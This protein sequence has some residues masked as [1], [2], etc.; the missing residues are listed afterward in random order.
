MSPRRLSFW[1]KVLLLA[2]VVAAADGLIFMA[3]GLGANLGLI[4]LT[5]VVALILAVPAIIRDRLSRLALAVAIL[6]ALLQIERASAVGWLL[7]LI[8]LGVAMLALR[9][10]RGEDAWKWFQ[11]LVV[12]ALKGLIAPIRDGRRLLQ[13]RARLR[14]RKLID[15]VLVAALPLLGGAVFLGLFAEANPVIA[16]VLGALRLPDADFARLAFGMAVALVVWA[17]L[18][19]GGLR[20]TLRLAGWSHD[21]SLPGVS[22]ASI[23]AS[24]MVFNAIFALQNG[25]DIA[26]LWGGVGLPEGM[27]F[28]EYAHRGAYP[29]IATALL[30]GLFVVVFLQPGSLTASDRRIRVLVTVWVAQN[31]FLVASTALRT[32]DYIDAYSLTRTRI[33]A[34]LWMGLVA[35]GLVLILWRLL[36]RRS[37]AWLVNANVLAAGA[38]L[39]LCSAIDLGAIAAAWNVRHAR[40]VGGRGVALDL[41]YMRREL[42]GAALLPLA[43]LETSAIS[44]DLRDRVRFVRREIQADVVNRQSGWREWRWRD[45]RR[46][47]ALERSL[48]EDHHRSFERRDCSGRPILPPA[49]AATPPLT[50]TAKP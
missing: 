18:R 19:P 10:P 22:T 17:T 28:A 23:A 40:E 21:R 9:A 3:H 14:P 7:F 42:G 30:A 6:F 16:Q 15:G 4:G 38:V 35:T 11:R 34:L 25:L 48:P 41:C 12:G 44:A 36:Q 32:L 5:W 43:Q 49:P 2:A 13:A 20:Q 31:L 26:Y 1:R 46:L 8:A 39:T 27:S 37:A 33:A 50:A 45:A 29:L 47:R 24:L